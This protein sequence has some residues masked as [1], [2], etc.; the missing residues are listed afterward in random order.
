MVP[1][2]VVGSFSLPA[3]ARATWRAQPLDAA[4]FEWPAGPPL[5][6][7]EDDGA[8][9]TVGDLLDA[10][11][12]QD[13]AP[14]H[15]ALAPDG[16]RGFLL[17]D[18]VMRFHQA[19]ATALRQ[20]ESLGAT[21]H[22]AFIA[23]TEQIG[24]RLRIGG[25]STDEDPA[26]GWLQSNLLFADEDIARRFMVEMEF[27]QAWD[28][29][30]SLTRAAFL[31]QQ[32]GLGLLPLDRQPH[33]A[34]LLERLLREDPQALFTAMREGGVTGL[35]D[36]PLHDT[37]ADADALRDALA[38][39]DA[40]A[41]A[42]AIELLAIRDPLAAEA[43]AS[44]LLQDPSEHVVRHAIRALGRLASDDAFAQLLALDPRVLR[45]FV[46]IALLHALEHSRAPGA[47][48]ILLAELEGPRVRPSSWAQRAAGSDGWDAEVAH[49][50]LVL[51]AVA[52]RRAAHVEP[53]LFTIF[54]CHP[55]APIRVAAANALARLQG[56]LAQA[57]AMPIQC[58]LMGM[59][60]ALNQDDDRR[61][62]LLGVDTKDE[63]LGIVRFDGID[64]A[65]LRAL[66][67]EGFANPATNQNESPAIGDFL[68]MLEEH[69]ELRVGGYTV[70]QSRADYRVS[71]DSIG[72]H[73]DDVPADRRDAVLSLFDQLAQTATNIDPGGYSHAC[74]WT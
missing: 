58:A 55:V 60:K 37:Y 49:A 57:H 29:D 50:Q 6:R 52:L 3:P 35:H 22:V 5:F 27:V 13:G 24:F 34:T 68:A 42:A 66:V 9:A 74:W 40:P 64:R 28:R 26:I 32:S 16:V 46:Q 10:L 12:E 4:A 1:L 62:A 51:E 47:D 72:V 8:F 7:G 67:D 53:N 69:P 11:A 2:V 30:P 73:L 14:N 44:E 59:G 61:A 48:R 31:A 17:P 15:C 56:P 25:P 33:H 36:R 21:G 45:G 63:S 43:A 54:D 19:I 38:R 41:R 70:P 65:T 39:A 20:G 71:V 18:A 23:F